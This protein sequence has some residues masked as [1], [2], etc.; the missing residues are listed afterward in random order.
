MINKDQ[1]I[2]TQV[3]AKIAA[4][5]TPKGD[6]VMT[7]I[8][9]WLLAFDATTDALL[10]KHNMTASDTAPIME[11]APQQTFEQ[12]T[13]IVQQAF[14]TAQVVTAGSFGIKVKGKQHG[15]IPE[16]LPA[17]CASKGVTEVWDNRD[18]LSENAKRPWFKSTSSEDAFWAPR[19]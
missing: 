9:N 12:A 14:P 1:S 10:G 19:K 7:N 18:K 16:W 2:I 11:T 6:D 13:A 5:L 4:E 17:A 3:A 15:P 8:S